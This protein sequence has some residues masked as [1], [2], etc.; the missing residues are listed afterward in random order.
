MNAYRGKHTSS[1]VPWAVSS[2]ASSHYRSRHQARNRK[3]KR[4][5]IAAV[6]LVLLMLAYP[7][8][9]ALLLRVDRVNLTSEDLPSDIGH[10]RIVFVS[11]V[12]YGFCFP[13]SRVASLVN[14]INQLKPDIVLFGGDMGDD[15]ASA[16]SFYQHLPSI[17]ARYAML[18][19]LGERDHGE[20]TLEQNLITDAMRNAGVTPLL[21]TA[22]GVRVGNSTI[23]VAGLDDVNAG[24]P[25]L[26]G[27]AARTAAEDYVIFL[28]HNPSIVSEAQRAVDRNGKLGWFDL[29]LFGH[30]H[31]GQILGLGP[32]MDIGADVEDHYRRGWLVENRSDLIISNGVGTSVLP[33]RLLRPPQIH[34]IDVS[35][36]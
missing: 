2:T 8:L 3:R 9:E 24:M 27:L 30:T 14:Q 16:V 10:L 7:F 12:H 13:D 31:G 36:P 20:D 11:D 19:V 25:D 28:S 34:C 26:S 32:L 22:A 4:W 17:H 15:P 1:S 29:A 35:Q 33:A 21:N 18:G 5:G 23:Y 6:I